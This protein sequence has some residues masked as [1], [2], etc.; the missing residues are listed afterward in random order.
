[1]NANTTKNLKETTVAYSYRRFSSAS[2]KQ[3]DGTSLQRQLAMA[4]EVCNAKGWT[5]VDMPPDAGVSAYKLTSGEMAANFHRGQLGIFLSKVNNGAIKPGSI[6][7][8]ERMDRFSRNYFDIVFPIWLN[9]LQSGIEIYNCAFD[10]HY[11]LEAIRKNSNIANQALMEMAQANEYSRNLSNR[12]GK[13]FIIKRNDIAKGLKVN[14][15]PWCPYWLDWKGDTGKEGVYSPNKHA[16]TV[17]RLVDEYLSGKGMFTIA[18]DL[19][20]DGTATMKGGKWCQ[21]IISHI[22]NNPTLIGTAT[23]K[24]VQYPNFYPALITQEQFNS[25]LAKL[26]DNK[27]RCGGNPLSD[28]VGNLFRNRLHCNTCGGAMYVERNSVICKNRRL[29]K[30]SSTHNANREYLESHV[31]HYALMEHPETLIGK[32]TLQH[33]N[34]IDILKSNREIVDKKINT[35]LGL[36]GVDNM[37]EVQV[38]LSEL[39]KERE[40]L[41]KALNKEHMA[42]LSTNNAGTALI[43]LRQIRQLDTEDWEKQENAIIDVDIKLQNNDVRKK[44]LPIVASLI[45]RIDI[46]CA[47]RMTKYRITTSGNEVGTWEDITI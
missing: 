3:R 2:G 32:N 22:L 16:D 7:I 9:L 18:K 26:S 1:M 4:Q 13:A 35:V 24:E 5:L 10:T 17:K 41:N 43:N 42:M 38:K 31:F 25:L 33:N 27:N 20:K 30:C 29:G 28:N 14:T 47:D 8:L 46:D 34:N 37:P 39:N 40:I 12:I 44:L 21:S 36:V 45:K 6:L 15:G 19:I 11:T 23:L